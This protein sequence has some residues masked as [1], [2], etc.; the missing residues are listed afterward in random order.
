[1]CGERD[2]IP[3]EVIAKARE[4]L[5]FDA[6]DEEA[7]SELYG[8]P[9]LI[10]GTPGRAESFITDYAFCEAATASGSTPWHIRPL[11]AAGKKLSGGA[12]TPAL[13]GRIVAWDIAVRI[14]ETSLATACPRCRLKYEAVRP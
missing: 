7:G 8:A 14:V 10:R 13:C 4:E 12:D 2:S 9:Q 11:T 5:G 1:M 6:E 3:P